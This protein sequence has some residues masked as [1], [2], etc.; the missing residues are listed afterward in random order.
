MTRILL[1]GGAGQIGWELARL[2]APLGTVITPS[3][4]DLDLGRPLEIARA[5]DEISP[6]VIINAAAYTAVDNAEADAVIAAIVNTEAPAALATAA[7]RHNALY[8][9]YSSD[10]VF[11]GRKEGAYH[12]DDPTAPLNV[13]GRTLRDGEI[14]VRNSGAEH[15]IFRTSWVY[16]ARRRNF[17]RAVLQQA[18]DKTELPVVANQV[19]A[20]TWAGLVAATTA[21]ALQQD[22][23]SRRAGTFESA[24]LHL[25]AAG[26]TSWHG[27][28]SAILTAALARGFRLKC[29]QPT[30]VSTADY[31]QGANRPLNS[32]LSVKKLEARYGVAM[33]PWETGLRSCLA[34]L[35]AARDGE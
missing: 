14:A 20:P 15:V 6:E 32:R 26:S 13:Y 21:L 25:T 27:F 31:A 30:P 19:G 5:I 1:L 11:D 23:A 8:V 34:E 33:P 12:E 29:T 35:S 24:T 4:Q 2:L 28:A 10:Y 17:L 16:S 9:Q 3:R 22:L 18:K 7:R